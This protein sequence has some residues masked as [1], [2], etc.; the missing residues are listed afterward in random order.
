MSIAR[1]AIVRFFLFK[2]MIV[3]TPFA[4]IFY[5]GIIAAAW[6]N[7]SRR[8]AS[9]IAAAEETA[10]RLVDEAI[11]EAENLKKNKLLEA[12]DEIRRRMKEF[13]SNADAKRDA[14]Q[15]SERRIQHHEENI[16]HRLDLL[17]DKEKEIQLAEIKT[18]EL[19]LRL[20]EKKDEAVRI[21]EEQNLRLESISGISREDAKKVLIEN[22]V[23]IAKTEAAQI[24]KDL[25]DAAKAE[26]KKEA[27]RIIMQA[28]QRTA[29]E[30]SVETTVSTVYL[31]SEEMKGRIIGREGRNIRTFESV[32]GVDLIVDDTPDAVIISSFDPFRREV[33]S[34][35]LE[36]LM[37]DGRM[38]PARIEEV[39]EKV[40]IELEEEIGRI[41]E[42]ALLELGIH[43]V[44]PEIIRHV[45]KMRYRTSYGQNLLKHSM[46]VAW[47]CGIMAA[48]LGL[49]TTTA[50]RAGLLH[51]IGKVIDRDTEGPHALLG[52]E[53]AK[54]FNENPFVANAIGS[55]HEDIAME[56]PYAA[57]V[58]SAD[59][60][61]GSRPGA[62]RESL[63][64]YIKRLEKLE[65]LALSFEGVV[66]TFALQAGR[67][68]RVIVEPDKVDD[69][70]ADRL[71]NDIA[72]KI[73]QDM[74]FPGQ[75]KV[76]VI[77]EK[78]STAYAK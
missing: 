9:K 18:R 72:A 44:H 54:R 70:T 38:H 31:Q 34:V 26:A 58:Q 5:S 67:E 16:R 53:L 75:I 57:L 13:E 76:I 6:W 73:R 48:E 30:H 36:R 21:I 56:T 65:S 17:T 12:Q 45:G 74:E 25:R 66:K 1:A 28:I 42:D 49:D 3:L 24:V 47:I 43:N 68:V 52:Y 60:I 50:K 69:L 55:H 14:L 40:R 2:N 64:G 20:Q 33:A 59:A 11:R 39:V 41:G 61:S 32:T 37:N 78:R 4:G 35:A 77:R 71:S 51:D 27:Q 10:R 23:N 7:N 15:S 63:E 29:S 46:E 8:S 19:H 22:F 62:R